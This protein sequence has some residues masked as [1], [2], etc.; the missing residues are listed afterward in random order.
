M[1]DCG[2]KTE[3]RG[4]SSE[5]QEI[6]QKF[7]GLK[8]V[9]IRCI[10]T[11]TKFPGLQNAMYSHSHSHSHSWLLR[12]L[13]LL[14]PCHPATARRCTAAALERLHLERERLR[15]RP[16]ENRLH[17]IFKPKKLQMFKIFKLINI[18]V[19]KH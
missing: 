12:L 4:Y 3:M 11:F 18:S 8:M 13:R 16:T 7:R 10:T 6:P 17:N 9:S 19:Y 5:T 15:N 14:R 2:S 1:R